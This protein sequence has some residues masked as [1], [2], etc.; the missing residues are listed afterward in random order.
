MDDEGFGITDVGEVGAEFQIV[1][2]AADLVD[3]ASLHVYTSAHIKPQIKST[4]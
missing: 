2:D 4:D 1:D 3:V